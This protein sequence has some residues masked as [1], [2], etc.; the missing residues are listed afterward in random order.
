[1]PLYADIR[2]NAEK[3]GEV[4]IGREEKLRAKNRNYHY[5]ARA[6]DGTTAHFI[7]NYSDG[8]EECLRKA[9][10]ALAEERMK[11][12]NDAEQA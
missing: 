11:N 8:A 1:M 5:Q 6:M 12:A 3:I 7:H 4:W 9:L 2:I 10:N